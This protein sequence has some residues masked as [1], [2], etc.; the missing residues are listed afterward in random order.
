[1]FA[2][3]E[4]M[5]KQEENWLKIFTSS[6]TRDFLFVIFFLFL[7]RAVNDVLTFNSS[8]EW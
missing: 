3:L 1:M 4:M 8:R 7:Y 6:G 2:D 5:W